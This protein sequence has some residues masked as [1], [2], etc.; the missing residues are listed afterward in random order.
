MLDHLR[1]MSHA[2]HDPD[3]T[4]CQ[5]MLW[6]V[7]GREFRCNERVSVVGA[8][9]CEGCGGPRAEVISDPREAAA[10]DSAPG[11]SIPQSPVGHHFTDAMRDAKLCDDLDHL[12]DLDHAG[13]DVNT[14]FCLICAV[15]HATTLKDHRTH[16]TVHEQSDR[17]KA[18]ALEVGAVSRAECDRIARVALTDPLLFQGRWTLEALKGISEYMDRAREEL[19]GAHSALCQYLCHCPVRSDDDLIAI[20]GQLASALALLEEVR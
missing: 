1:P 2:N 11:P 20:T 14:E 16:R 7:N 12:R 6:G 3:N 18:W 13:V 4:L 10:R 9:F 8:R 17:M 5:N 15:E 19:R